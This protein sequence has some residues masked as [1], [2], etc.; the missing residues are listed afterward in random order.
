MILFLSSQGR[1]GTM[2]LKDSA[3]G[4]PKPT[5]AE[6]DS[7]FVSFQEGMQVE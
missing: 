1:K 6:K 5:L 4:K 7:K 3:K 2:S